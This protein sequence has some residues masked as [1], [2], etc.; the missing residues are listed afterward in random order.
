MLKKSG[1]PLQ[2]IVRRLDEESRVLSSLRQ[3]QCI[4]PD[5][6]TLQDSHCGGPML[7]GF[8]RVEQLKKF[9]FKNTFISSCIPDNCVFI[10]DGSNKFKVILVQNWVRLNDGQIVYWERDT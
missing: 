7:R 1:R 3:S 5:R 2:Q 9:S 6:L 10:G 4:N 8:A